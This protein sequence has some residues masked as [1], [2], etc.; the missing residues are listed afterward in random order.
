MAGAGE[1]WESLQFSGTAFSFWKSPVR[2]RNSRCV[3]VSRHMVCFVRDSA[4]E[5][6]RS[7]VSQCRIVH[8]ERDR[9][10]PIKNPV[11]SLL[12]V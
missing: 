1:G 7:V 9:R 10:L 6:R 2:K 5:E 4:V 3:L 8:R 11:L 12:F